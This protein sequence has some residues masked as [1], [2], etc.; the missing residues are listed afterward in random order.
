VLGGGGVTGIAWQIGLVAGLAQA[1]VFLRDAECFI[2]T[3][4]GSVVA[5]QLAGDAPLQQLLDAQL[6]PASKSVE[7]FRP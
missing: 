4:A 6:G 5:A 2:G 1:G 7:Q 3:S